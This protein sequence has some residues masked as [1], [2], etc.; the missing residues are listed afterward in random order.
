MKDD[1]I[2]VTEK[3]AKEYA[4]Y[5]VEEYPNPYMKKCIKEGKT[6]MLNI[7]KEGFVVCAEKMTQQ[8]KDW[9][10][11]RPIGEDVYMLSCPDYFPTELIAGVN[12]KGLFSEDT[13][14]SRKTGFLN[15]CNMGGRSVTVR[16]SKLAEC[17]KI[18]EANHFPVILK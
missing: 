10:L 9:Y 11:S 5:V 4:A 15:G 12:A 1:T 14:L 18:L 13:S 7:I 3:Q 8:D 2:Y 16:T 17:V 6:F